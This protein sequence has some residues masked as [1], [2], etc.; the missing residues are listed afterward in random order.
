MAVTDEPTLLTRITHERLS[1]ELEDLTTRGRV[2]IARA[3]E[4]ARALGDLSENGDYHAAKDSQGRWRRDPPAPGDARR[5]RIVD[6]VGRLRRAWSPARSSSIRYEGDDE[7]ERYLVGSIEERHDDVDVVSPAP[8]SAR[9]CSGKVAGDVVEY[10]APKGSCASRSS[11]SETDVT[12]DGHAPS[13]RRSGTATSSTAAEGEPDLLYIDLHL[14]HEVT[15]PQ[16]FEG[17]RLAGRTVRR[18]ELT[19]ATADHNVPTTDIDKPIADPIS[20]QAARVARGQLRRVRRHLLPDGRPEP[21]HRPRHRPR[22]GPHP[23]GHDDR[24][25]RQPHLDP[26]RL[27]GPRLRDRH[28]GGRARARHPDASP[29][30]AEDDGRRGRG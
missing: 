19:V 20:R 14:V 22:A 7:I 13:S 1:R 25:R 27:R 30:P 18:P 5:G 23:A 8:H 26:R 17:L 21:G 11:R 15:S 24:L 10:E 16:A 6:D 28:L 3:I 29:A 9:H 2:E 12:N 4:A